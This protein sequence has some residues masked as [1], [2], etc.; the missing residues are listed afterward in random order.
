MPDLLSTSHPDPRVLR[1]NAAQVLAALPAEAVA[2]GEA[3]A[4]AGHE[5]ALVGG[6]VRDAFLGR[7]SDDL[8]FATS[9]PP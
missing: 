2:L 8:D 3:F 9:A 4:E 1:R 6:P 5:L 7:A